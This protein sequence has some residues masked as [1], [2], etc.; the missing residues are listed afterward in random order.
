MSDIGHRI[1]TSDLPCCPAGHRHLHCMHP[2]C[3]QASAA[4]P[5][6]WPPCRPR[7]CRCSRRGSQ[8][9]GCTGGG[10]SSGGGP[11][12]AERCGEASAVQGAQRP[13]H[14][15]HQQCPGTAAAEG[16]PQQEL[17]SRTSG[18]AAQPAGCWRQPSCIAHSSSCWQPSCRAAPGACQQCRRPGSGAGQPWVGR[19]E[20]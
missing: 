11:R 10:G 8:R 17:L 12:P 14:P 9:S 3:P 15:A 5:C 1:G 13:T 7:C 2:W 18:R 20:R 19:G 4:R 16:R 6:I